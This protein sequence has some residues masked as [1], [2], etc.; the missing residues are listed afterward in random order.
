MTLLF[1]GSDTIFDPAFVDPWTVVHFL[2]GGMAGLLFK[3]TPVVGGL[4]WLILHSMYELKDLVL[5]MRHVG[6]RM[7][8]DEVTWW[9][10]NSISNSL[11]DTIFT[12][13]GFA[14]GIASTHSQIPIEWLWV[15]WLGCFVVFTNALLMTGNTDPLYVKVKN[16]KGEA[17][18]KK[19]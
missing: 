15:L 6:G 10:N 13:G 17:E 12:M 3:R 8:D 2:V 7:K 4:I 16:N 14:L 1:A 18:W 9:G 5:L 11:G 19:V